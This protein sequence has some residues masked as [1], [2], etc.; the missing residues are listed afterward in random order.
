MRV[1]VTGAAGFLGS[2]LVD[3]LVAD[4]HDVLGVDNLRRGRKDLIR[5]HIASGALDFRVIDIRMLSQ[6]EDAMA[7]VES[8][9]HLAAQSN[10]MGAFSDPDYA[11][12][13]NVIGTYNVL[14]AARNAGVKHLVFSSSR[15]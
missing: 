12:E 13:S 10:V 6:L 15:E 7:G 14:K 2:H 5:Q 3:R 1:L 9:Y 4:G 11:F 8:V